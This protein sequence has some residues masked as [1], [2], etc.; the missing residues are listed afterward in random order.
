MQ[1]ERH[2]LTLKSASNLTYLWSPPVDN[3]CGS[4]L[5]CSCQ[6]GGFLDKEKSSSWL[7]ASSFGGLQ[8]AHDFDFGQ[9]N[10]LLGTEMIRINSNLT[11]SN[12]P[13][14]I[15]I[16]PVYQSKNSLGLARNSTLLNRLLSAGLINSRTWEYYSG[17]TDAETQ[18]Q[19]NGSVV[20]E[21]YD[22]AKKLGQ[23]TTLI[24]SDVANCPTGLLVTVHDIE[25]NL[26]DGRNLSLLGPSA[27]SAMN[28]CVWP[29]SPVLGL[30]VEVWN[31]FVQFSGVNVLGRSVGINFWAMLI[32]SNGSLVS[33]Y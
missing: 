25:L 14:G 19:L 17:W 5:S 4:L 20:L 23:N 21:G 1:K 32:S 16:R 8:N 31:S 9:Y 30:P 29:T 6:T 24:V 27:G 7:Q 18:H 22:E 11:L 3:K 10:Y 28:A 13:I 15:G 2:V 12:F 33:F 26:L